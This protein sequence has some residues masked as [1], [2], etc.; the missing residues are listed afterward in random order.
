MSYSI[1]EYPPSILALSKEL[2]NH[3]ELW[4]LL[5]TQGATDWAGR[6][7]A[8][9]A[10][11]GLVLDGA[12]VSSDIEYIARKCTEKLIQSRTSNIILLN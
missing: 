12:Y 10:H 11:C 9:A 6:V 4:P 7:G 5:D 8:I 3:P 1:V 2:A